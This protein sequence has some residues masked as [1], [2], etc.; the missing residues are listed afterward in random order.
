MKEVLERLFENFPA[1]LVFI[2]KFISVWIAYRQG[3]SDV[4]NKANEAVLEKIKRKKERDLANVDI[5]AG[6]LLD[7]Y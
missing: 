2:D 5:S 3:K 4:I 1:I 6:E 7:K